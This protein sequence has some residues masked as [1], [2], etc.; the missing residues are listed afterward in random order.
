M[1]ATPVPKFGAVQPTLLRAKPD[2]SSGDGGMMQKRKNRQLTNPRANRIPSV[3]FPVSLVKMTPTVKPKVQNPTTKYRNRTPPRNIHFVTDADGM[4]KENIM[5]RQYLL[6][7]SQRTVLL[8]IEQRIPQVFEE[9]SLSSIATTVANSVRA[10]LDSRYSNVFSESA[11]QIET[12]RQIISNNKN[13]PIEAGKLIQTVISVLITISRINSLICFCSSWEKMS[14]EGAKE[15]S[16]TRTTMGE[17]SDVSFGS[18]DSTDEIESVQQIQDINTQE[19]NFIC[20]ICEEVIP[21]DMIEEHSALCIQAHLS[22]YHFYRCGERLKKIR[23][24]I[25]DQFLNIIWPGDQEQSTSVVFPILYLYYLTGI[26]IDIQNADNDADEQLENILSSLSKYQP[27]IPT[28]EFAHV[29]SSCIQLITKKMHC[30]NE[31]STTARAIT[32]TTRRHRA[33]T[34]GGFT[35]LLCDFEFLAK[36]SSGAFARVYLSRKKRTGDLYAIKVIKRSNIGQKNQIRKVSTERDI[37]RRLHSPYVVNFYYSFVEKNNL[38]LV[39]EFIPGGDIFSLLQNVGCLSEEHTKVYAAQIVKALQFLRQNQIIHRDLKPDNILINELGMLKLADFGLSYFGASVKITKDSENKSQVVGTPDY[40][41]PEIIMN[42]PHT[43]AV[44]YWALGC[45]IFEMLCGIPPFHGDDEVDTFRKILTGSIEWDDLEECSNEVKDL[46]THL[47]TNDPKTRL[48]SKHIEDIMR[49]PWFS[50]IDWDSIDK[51]SPVF[52]PTANRIDSYKDYFV[53]RYQFNDND[54]SDIREDMA[55]SPQKNSKNGLE[56]EDIEK[57]PMVSLQHLM[58]TNEELANK[59]RHT[60]RASNDV[61]KCDVSDFA[62]NVG[63]QKN[64]K[65]WASSIDKS[66]GTFGS[67]PTS[68]PL[69]DNYVDSFLV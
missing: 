67:A 9:E 17:F 4:G 47:L 26:A 7:K 5:N 35:T 25:A 18:D 33:S 60:R 49:H 27:P 29:I 56:D 8:R 64:L 31:I 45:I 28:L 20:R 36:L 48:G 24:N 19:D 21:L 14:T 50:D 68:T 12:F 2:D 34:I 39:M 61:A 22:Q 42:K 55:C 3:R 13:L 62:F 15:N 58:S 23:N 59:I 43:F 57:F 32:R 51:L 11:Q 54:E 16:P 65:P 41:A 1:N 38:Y 40:M 69:S 63:S 30:V 6:L 53:E 10:V 66:E 37:M 52:V 44:D 46:I